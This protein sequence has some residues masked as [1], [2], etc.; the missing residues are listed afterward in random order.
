[1]KRILIYGDSNTWGHG[2][3]SGKLPE[4]QTWP[5]ILQQILGGASLV[6]QEGLPGRI[7]GDHDT[8]TPYRNGKTHFEAIL[9]TALPLDYVIIAL[10]ANDVKKK[11]GL[12]SRQIFDDLMWYRGKTAEI[13]P[14]YKGVPSTPVMIFLGI[15][16]SRETEY[17]Q[18]EPRVREKVNDYLKRAGEIYVPLEHLEISDDGVHFTAADHQYVA[19]QVFAS[20]RDH[21]AY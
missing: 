7:A 12:T 16:N 8:E 13:A 21:E 15:P 4:T 2:A 5:V 20:I 1:M 14:S 9:R 18:P 19:Q 17:Y 10:G 11:Y 6:I 3:F